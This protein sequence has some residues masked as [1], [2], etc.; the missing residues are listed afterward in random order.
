MMRVMSRLI[1]LVL[2]ALVLTLPQLGTGWAQS[3]GELV[4]DAR[5]AA[6]ENRNK[7][8]AEL[9]AKAIEAAPGERAGLLREYADQLTYSGQSGEAVLLFREFLSAEHSAEERQRAERGLALALLW[10]G[11]A[12][13]A[14]GAWQRILDAA[15]DDADARKNLREALV[16]AARTAAF[17]NQNARAADYFA[18]AVAAD[19]ARRQEILREYAD[20]LTYSGRSAEAVTL[21]RERLSAKDLSAGEERQAR[22]GLALAFLWSN[23]YAEAITT[24]R[25]VLRADPRDEDARKNLSNALVG[26]AR[27]AASFDR[28]AESASLFAEAIKVAPERRLELAVEYAN[29]LTYSDR[30]AKAVPIYREA[31]QSG[32]L[33][34]DQRRSAMLGL[35]LALNWSGQAEEALDT[36]SEILE[37]SPDT[38][39][40]LVGRGNVLTQLDRNKE[41][42]ADFNRAIELSPENREAI[43]NGAQA[44]S[45]L[46]RQRMALERLAPLLGGSA[47][48]QTR[49]VAARAELWKGRPDNASTLV[50]QMLEAD[51]EDADALRIEGEIAQA[52]RPLSEVDGFVSTQNN[53]LATSGGRLR[54][55]VSVNDGLGVVGAQFRTAILDPEEGE[56]V[57]IAGAGVFGRNRFNDM[58]EINASLFLNRVETESE[59][60]YEPTY[61][62]WLTL[63]PSDMM[64]FDLSTSRTYFDD[65]ESMEKEIVMETVGLSMDIQADPDLRFSARGS[66]GFISDGNHRIFA[67]AEAERRVL[68]RMPTVF[69]GARYT[70]TSFSEP[71][72]ANGYFNTAWLHSIEATLRAEWQPAPGWYIGGGASAGYEWQPEESKP[73][74]GGVL[75]TS[76]APNSSVAFALDVSHQNSN[77]TGGS[78]AFIRTTVSGGLDIRW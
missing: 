67:Q 42:L 59:S 28:N 37:Q 69:A 41:A 19:P 10:S 76:Y 39:E 33:R 45:F 47:D 61:D 66:Y 34:G 35:A 78:D 38:V 27:E 50:R 32:K 60:R 52:Q 13:E 53:G 75:S 56:D 11:E 70:Y 8:S 40:A 14:A 12:E 26:A 18:R 65:V 73:I 43:R 23:R 16:S 49:L 62:V 25:T 22:R 7:E 68:R 4:N 55:G 2:L 15:P 72:L 31:L 51:P 9:F 58:V 5:L 29:Q 30:A 46:G 44:L 77:L 20:Q 6:R 74:W 3:F 48:R 1:T 57:R 24:W 17:R 54:H 71:E 21:Y 64:R 36:Y 63:W